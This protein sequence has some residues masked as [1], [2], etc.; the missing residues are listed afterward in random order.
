LLISDPSWFP[1]Y[2]CLFDEYVNARDRIPKGNL[3]EV[4]IP[5]PRTNK[6]QI[7]WRVYSI[8]RIQ[9]RAR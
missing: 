6:K 8:C 5:W 3:V 7:S 1:R 2:D 4:I 9:V